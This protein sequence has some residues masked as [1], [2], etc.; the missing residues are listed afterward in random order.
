MKTTM[1]ALV[2]AE[3]VLA[4]LSQQTV[5]ARTAYRLAKL[6]AAVRTDTKHFQEQRNEL[7]KQLGEERQATDD[8]R[9]ASGEG[10]V[11]EVKAENRDAFVARLNELAAIEVSIEKWRLTLEDLEAFSLSSNDVLALGDL[12]EEPA[13]ATEQAAG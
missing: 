13:P 6:T 9:A 8:E 7:I 4:K 11:I 12:I 5:S 10:T 2:Q 3:Q 1:G